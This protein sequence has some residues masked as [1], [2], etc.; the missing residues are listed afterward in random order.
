MED[1]LWSENR[2]KARV[3]NEDR[4]MVVGAPGSGK[5]AFLIA[6]VVDWMQSGRSVVL[7]DVKPEIYGRLL[8]AGVFERYGYTPT[9]FNPT[10]I[11]SHAYNL[12]S[13]S[14]SSA[15]LNEIL[16][17]I[18]PYVDDSSEVF[19]ENARRL[20]KA[21]LLELGE[22]ASLPNAQNSLTPKIILLTFKNSE[23]IK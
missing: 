7:T 20:L 10:D 12:F 14:S 4:G 2:F 18:I 19:A 3:S 17:V 5:T 16:S 23:K 13:E 8:E 6:Q 11:H 22:E 21:V 9:V 15:E 1:D